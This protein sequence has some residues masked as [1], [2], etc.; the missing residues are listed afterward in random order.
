M[1]LST[2]P[3]YRALTEASVPGFLAGIPAVAERLGG[4]PAEWRVGEVGD[5]NLNLVFLVE[6]PAGGCCVKQALPYVRLV[7]ESWPMPLER[8]FF[9]C[10]WLKAHGALAPGRVPALLHYDPTLFALVMERLAPHV[11]LRRGLVEGRSY[12]ELAGH[13]AD[14]CSRTLFFTSDL[15]VG[16]AEKKGR[17]AVFCGNAELCKITEDL[18][19]TDP[20]RIHERNRWT[21]PQLDRIAEEFRRDAPLKIAVSRLKLKFMVSAEALIHGDL[22][23][24]SMMVTS[25]DTRIIDGEFAFYGPMGFDLGAVIGNLLMNYFSQDGHA[26]ADGPREAYGEWVLETAERF[27]KGFAEMFLGLWRANPTGDAYT[28]DLFTDPA[29]AKALEAERQAYMRRLFAD[30]VGFAAAKTIRRIL[31]LAHNIDFELI[32]DPDR[33]ALCEARAL[34]LARELMVNTG[35]YAS[36]GAVTAAARR[37]RAEGA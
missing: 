30:T 18:I 32:A 12:P 25:D 20:Y 17:M 34:R 26:S 13:L 28:G 7:G 4:K 16:A 31:G 23:T 3:G 11:I 5:G 22:H 33:R 14:Y 15:A 36:I 9:E 37:F 24:G 1:P 6:G 10:E 8:A 35:D 21:S 27:W 19:F 29:G 2:P